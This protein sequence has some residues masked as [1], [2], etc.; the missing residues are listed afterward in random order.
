MRLRKSSSGRP[1]RSMSIRRRTWRGS[2]AC[3]RRPDPVHSR[4]P[5]ARADLGYAPAA[6]PRA[7]GNNQM[8]MWVYEILAP[9]VLFRHIALFLLVVAMAM[10]TALMLR[11]VALAS[12]IV[13]LILAAAIA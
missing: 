13:A 12:G 11:F 10:P 2:G 1:S 5:E 9:A 8:L 3:L 4:P 6:P 7:R